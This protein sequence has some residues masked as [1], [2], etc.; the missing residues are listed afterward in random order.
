M[1][2]GEAGRDPRQ[3]G[4]VGPHLTG[5]ERA[6]DAD[7]QRL[8]VL[9]RRPETVDRLAAECP[10]REIDDRDADPERQLRRNLP[11]SHQRSLRVQRVEDR[12]DQQQVYTTAQ[13]RARRLGIRR[14][15]LVERDVAERWIVHVRPV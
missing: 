11:R 5:A 14:N 12:L 10:S 1:R 4:D 8:G 7:D 6:I 9:D 15:E 2:R 3:L 13:Q